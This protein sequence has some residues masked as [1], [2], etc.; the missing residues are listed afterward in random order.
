MIQSIYVQENTSCE[1]RLCQ[2]TYEGFTRFNLLIGG[3]GVGKTTLLRAIEKQDEL[4]LTTTR[5]IR[6]YL[7]QNSQHNHRYVTPHPMMNP[8]RFTQM[9]YQKVNAS[10]MSEGQS[11]I[12]SLLA[13]FELLK[14]K[15]N[16]YPEMTIVALFDEADSGLSVDHLNMIMHL[17]MELLR[18]YPNIQV[19]A[20]C[21]QYHWIYCVKKVLNLQTGEWLEIQDYESFCEL[22]FQQMTELGTLREHCFLAE[23]M[24]LTHD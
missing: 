19:I 15:A 24:C 3:N 2:T 16:N 17:W 6:P 8:T 21:N 5:P 12:Y 13:F 14:E 11:I 9:A 7:Y 10:Q 4:C 18:D 1:D 23:S 22:Y 20:S